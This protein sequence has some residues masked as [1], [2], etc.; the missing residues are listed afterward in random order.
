MLSRNFSTKSDFLSQEVGGM[1]KYTKMIEY[2]YKKQEN[3][4][5][6]NGHTMFEGDVLQRLQRLAHL[7]EQIKQ[8]EL[9]PIDNNAAWRAMLAYERNCIEKYDDPLNR[10]PSKPPIKGER[11]IDYANKFGVTIEEMKGQA[12]KVERFLEHN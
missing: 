11:M 5:T 10:Y 2:K 9:A 12:G 6:E 1:L 3:K 4:F 7:E 8:G